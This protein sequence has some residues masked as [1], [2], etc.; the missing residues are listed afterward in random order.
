M[1]ILKIN[2]CMECP[3]AHYPLFCTLIK[4]IIIESKIPDDCPLQDVEESDPINT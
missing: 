2:T 4:R 1:K 3:K